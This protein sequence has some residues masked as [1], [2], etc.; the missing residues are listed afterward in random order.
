M[1][2]LGDQDGLLSSRGVVRYVALILPIGIHNIDFLAVIPISAKGNLFTAG[3]PAWIRVSEGMVRYVVLIVPRAIHNVDF[4]VTIPRGDKGDFPTVRRP[5]RSIVRRA[6]VGQSALICPI[7]IYNVDFPVLIPIGLEGDFF[8]SG[9]QAGYWSKPG[10][11]VS[12]NG[13]P[14]SAPSGRSL[15]RVTS[16][17]P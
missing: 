4:K 12:W 7:G 10:L 5:S 11:L 3:R 1:L 9:D 16:Q 8:P 13:L 6:M 2:P 17:I 14:A 15:L